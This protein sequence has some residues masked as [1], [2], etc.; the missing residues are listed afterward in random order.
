MEPSTPT[1]AFA[2]I[3]I[4]WI[5]RTSRFLLKSIPSWSLFLYP[6]SYPLQAWPRWRPSQSWTLPQKTKPFPRFKPWRRFFFYPPVSPNVEA[7][8][9]ARS[10]FAP[11]PVPVRSIISI[12]ILFVA[13]CRNCKS[14]EHTSELQSLRHLVCRLLLEKKKNQV[15]SLSQ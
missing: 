8:Q 14:E 15:H 2:Q 7:I 13:I 1:R 6:N 11:Q 9:E 3:A 10:S 5:G 12:C 4:T